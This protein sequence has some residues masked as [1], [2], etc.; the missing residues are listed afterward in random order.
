MDIDSNG[1]VTM[2]RKGDSTS[3][4]KTSLNLSKPEE[5]FIFSSKQNSGQLGNQ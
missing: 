2:L 5:E 4:L 3:T 1:S